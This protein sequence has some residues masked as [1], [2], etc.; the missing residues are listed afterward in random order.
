MMSIVTE[1]WGH[2]FMRNALLAGILLGSTCGLLGCFVVLRGLAF[3]GDALSH[4]VLPGVVIAHFFRLP[5]VLGGVLAA[6]CA[7]VTMWVVSFE[8]RLKNDVVI[9][10]V[11]PGYFALGV[12]ML[13]R[14]KGYTRD[15]AHILFG[16]VLAVR[17][18]DLILQAVLF[19]AVVTMLVAFYP[20]LVATTFDPEY[21]RQVGISP[22]RA[23]LGLLVTL[24]ITVVS[25]VQAVGTVLVTSLLIT[26]AATARMF[27]RRLSS[28]LALSAVLGCLSTT[29]GLYISY[30]WGTAAGAS[31][32]LVAVTQF[33]LA[34]FARAVVSKTFSRQ[35]GLCCQ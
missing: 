9:G 1:P 11:F 30:Y 27:S 28:M 18:E 17:T 16:N 3:V 21:S 8:R 12:M 14:T 7:V 25:G 34:I 33:V 20:E 35:G 29:Q 24:A 10:V 23:H 13:S 22:E 15:L 26:P 32:I 6:L 2:E 31:I 19:V 5:I 4:S